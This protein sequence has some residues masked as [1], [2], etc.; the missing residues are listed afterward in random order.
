V[1]R[2]E[3]KIGHEKVVSLV[4]RARFPYPDEKHPRWRTFVNSPELT[5]GIDTTPEPIYPDILVIDETKKEA[6]MIGEVETEMTVNEERAKDWEKYTSLVP[7]FYVY[8]PEGRKDAA[9]QLLT[10]KNI[11]YTGLRGYS[12]GKNGKLALTKT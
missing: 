7:T 5:M 8:V 2:P 10:T 9:E 1:S 11:R 4:A 12:Y 3:E 6:V